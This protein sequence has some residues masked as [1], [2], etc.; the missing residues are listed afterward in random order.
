MDNYNTHNFKSGDV[1][2]A[3][4]ANDVDNQTKVLTEGLSALQQEISRVEGIFSYV[5]IGEVE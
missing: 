4:A 5:K 3:R 2:T 1:F